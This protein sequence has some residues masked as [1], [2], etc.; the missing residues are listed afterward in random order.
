MLTTVQATVNALG[1][2]RMTTS[3]AIYVEVS[4]TLNHSPTRRN[5]TLDTK[6]E[7]Q[8]PNLAGTYSSSASR[9]S[10]RESSTSGFLC[11]LKPDR[12]VLGQDFSGLV[13]MATEDTA[14][15]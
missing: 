5:W 12:P 10:A 9:S 4:T 14:T 3:A 7:P 6:P 11:A 2:K 15:Q 8:K 1:S 13:H